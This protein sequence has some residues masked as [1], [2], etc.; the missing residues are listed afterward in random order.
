MRACVCACVCVCALAC[1]LACFC[2]CVFV[3]AYSI[4][5]IVQADSSLR[6]TLHIAE[7]LINQSTYKHSNK[8]TNKQIKPP[9]RSITLDRLSLGGRHSHEHENNFETG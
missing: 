5:K 2:A 8:Q 1:L 3:A 4:G 7:T 9:T 6:Y